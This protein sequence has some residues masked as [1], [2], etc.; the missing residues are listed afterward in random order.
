M[1]PD[2]AVM[3]TPKTA[4]IEVKAEPEWVAWVH[5]A[6]KDKGVSVAGYTRMVLTERMRTDGIEPPAPA[7]PRGK[8]PAD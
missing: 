4:K 7:K 2:T 6:A 3:A 1:F 5:K 8:R